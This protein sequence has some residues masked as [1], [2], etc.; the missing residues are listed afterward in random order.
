MDAPHLRPRLTSFRVLAF[1]VT[2]HAPDMAS[3]QIGFELTPSIELALGVPIPPNEVLD[4]MVRISIKGHTTHEGT[5]PNQPLAEFSA[6]YE[7]RYTYPLGSTEA[8]IS[9]R[10][11]SE[12]HQYMLVAQAFPLASS[13]CR[14]EL[15]MMGFAVGGMP[16]G[17]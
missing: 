16:L 15:A 13:H 14:R 3:D 1:H 4:G 7:A 8:Q 5:A 2:N 6:V 11:E 12:T 10:F 9:P 17:L